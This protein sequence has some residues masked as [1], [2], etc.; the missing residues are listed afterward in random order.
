[1]YKLSGKFKKSDFIGVDLN[2]AAINAGIKWAN[3]H[4]IKNV[5]LINDDVIKWV[6]K[7]EFNYFCSCASLIYLSENELV[8]TF[9]ILIDM[10]VDGIYF[11]EPASTNGKLIKRHIYIYPYEN[12]FKLLKIEKYYSI[13]EEVFEYEPWKGDGYCGKIFMLNRI[14][15]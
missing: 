1:M 4:K 15:K 10:R 12:I 5:K 13:S 14:K 7:I 8:D 11:C 3:D 9:K 6:K 2:G